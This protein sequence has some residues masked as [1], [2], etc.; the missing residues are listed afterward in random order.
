MTTLEEI[1]IGSDLGDRVIADGVHE[2]ID[3]IDVFGD[4]HYPEDFRRHVLQ[5]V[6]RRALNEAISGSEHHHVQ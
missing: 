2:T 5:G 4:H 3:G 1:I 6:L